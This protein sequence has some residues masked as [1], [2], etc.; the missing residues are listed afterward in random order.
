MNKNKILGIFI[1]LALLITCV[2]VSFASNDFDQTFVDDNSIDDLEIDDSDLDDSFIDDE[3]YDDESDLDDEDWEDLDDEDWDD[4]LDDE[5][6]NYE[7]GDIDEYDDIDYIDE[8]N[9]TEDGKVYFYRVVAYKNGKA[10]GCA[11]MA[12]NS[13]DFDTDNSPENKTD[14]SAAGSKNNEDSSKDTYTNANNYNANVHDTLVKTI[15]LGDLKNTITPND[16]KNTSKENTSTNQTIVP[17]STN[18][19][20]GIFAILALILVSLVIFI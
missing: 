9:F 13:D 15:D 2:G 20:L 17:E 6:W 12:S 4:D 3:D 10:L 7:D 18:D 8:G 16:S 14:S 5:D 11:Y 19:N 1:L